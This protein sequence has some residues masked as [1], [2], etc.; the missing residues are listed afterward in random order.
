MRKLVILLAAV[1]VLAAGCGG[2]SSSSSKP[3]TKE[4]Y[5]AKLEST[6]KE[7][8]DQIGTKQS[9]IDKMSAAASHTRQEAPPPIQVGI[10]I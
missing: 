7:I 2:G 4:E 9:N 5:Q 8:A 6:A 10:R 1:A 3:L